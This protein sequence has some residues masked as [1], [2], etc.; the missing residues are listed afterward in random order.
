MRSLFALTLL[1]VCAQSVAAIDTVPPRVELTIQVETRGMTVGEGR[2][3]F[4]HDGKHYTVTTEARTTGVARLFKRVEEKRESR[5][6][7]N[8][9]G[10]R[11]LTFKQQRTGKQPN[12]AT[13]DYEKKQLTIQEGNETE[14]LPLL[15]N[16]IT[17]DATSLTYAFVFGDPPKTDKFTVN[18]TDGRKVSEYK[19]ALLGQEKLKTRMGELETLHYKKIQDPDDKRGFEFWLALDHHRLPVRVRI[20]EKDGSA[21]DSNVTK[22]DYGNKP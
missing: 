22:I 19:V 3:V 21:F 9:Q 8:A 15:P 6:L 17:L 5:G 2:D 16:A 7:V 18:V 14:V 12:G 1:T 11:P 10:L 4:E 20:I 13:F